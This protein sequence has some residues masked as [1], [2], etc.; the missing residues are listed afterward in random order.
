L[1]L[2]HYLLLLWPQEME[3]ERLAREAEEKEK[4]E[5]MK[6]IKEQFIDP[7]NQ[8]EKDKTDIQNMAMLEKAKDQQIAEGAAAAGVSKPGAPQ[9]GTAVVNDQAKKAVRLPYHASYSKL[10]NM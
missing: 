4:A 9:D 6:K 2:R 5:R 7:N 10:T 3:Q 1:F 8:W